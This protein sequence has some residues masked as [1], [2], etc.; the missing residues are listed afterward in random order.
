[1]EGLRC[2]HVMFQWGAIGIILVHYEVTN[3]AIFGTS[4]GVIYNGC[5]L[6]IELDFKK[7]LKEKP[8]YFTRNKRLYFNLIH[9]QLP[10]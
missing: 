2:C 1:M 4:L 3:Y 8:C 10:K 5:W 7:L 6:S 9:A